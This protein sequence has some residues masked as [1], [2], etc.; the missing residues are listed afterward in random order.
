MTIRN[1]SWSQWWHSLDDKGQAFFLSVAPEVQ[2]CPSCRLLV[3]AFYAGHNESR[4]QHCGTTCDGPGAVTGP[5]L[6]PDKDGEED[7]D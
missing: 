4:C 7:D 5:A 3:V 6:W 2:W 1:P